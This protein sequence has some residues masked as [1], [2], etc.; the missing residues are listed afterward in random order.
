MDIALGHTLKITKPQILHTVL[1][2]ATEFL[3][4]VCFFLSL[5]NKCLL[6]TYYVSSTELSI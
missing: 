6:S 4:A 5:V 1:G 2:E 3:Q